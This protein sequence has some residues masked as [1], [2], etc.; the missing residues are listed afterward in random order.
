MD[1]WISCK[2]RDGFK[3]FRG[4]GHIS[5]PAVPNSQA[6][7]PSEYPNIPFC[8]GAGLRNR[9][10]DPSRAEGFVVL[11]PVGGN[12]YS[13]LHTRLDRPWGPPSLLY[14]GYRCHS[15]G[16]NYRDMT[17]TTHPPLCLHSLLR[18]DLSLPSKHSWKRSLLC[19]LR[20]RHI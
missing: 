11:F 13:L 3:M 9:Y 17:L 18:G 6:L 12:S 19:I 4:W 16:I 7:F 2:I 15:P 20:T 10:S 5:N 1:W 14:N 8:S